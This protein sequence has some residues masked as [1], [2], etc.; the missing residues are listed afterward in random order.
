MERNRYV[1][2]VLLALTVFLVIVHEHDFED[3]AMEQLA[4]EGQTLPSADD[5]IVRAFSLASDEFERGSIQKS[6]TFGRFLLGKAADLL[7]FWAVLAA[8]S[9]KQTADASKSRRRR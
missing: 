7:Y 3:R 1:T 5:V 8:R 2:D 6:S 9:A 4:E